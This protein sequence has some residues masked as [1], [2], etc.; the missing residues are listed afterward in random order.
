MITATTEAACLSDI[1]ADW[2]VVA[3]WP[4]ASDGRMTWWVW[5]L[6]D[7]DREIFA[8]LKDAGKI[9]T[10]IGHQPSGDLVLYAKFAAKPVT[11]TA[12]THAMVRA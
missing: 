7:Q 10:V 2:C 6:A 12:G 8:Q 5:S 9:I 1:G 3:S 4:G 11:H